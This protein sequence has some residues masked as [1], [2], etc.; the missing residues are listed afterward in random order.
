MS[1]LAMIWMSSE[2]ELGLPRWSMAVCLLP[3]ACLSHMVLKQVRSSMQSTLDEHG[4]AMRT[5]VTST[6]A[7]Q[8]WMATFIQLATLRVTPPSS[9]SQR[10]A[11]SSVELPNIQ[12]ISPIP[13]LPTRDK[14]NRQLAFRSI[15]VGHLLELYAELGIP[16]W[17]DMPY[18][19]P[20]RSTTTD[21]GRQAI[22]PASARTRAAYATVVNKGV[23]SFA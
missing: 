11:S 16:D 8:S 2:L 19:N 13:A 18:F 14:K 23:P 4:E 7:S 1:Y 6:Y 20:A 12:A 5:S 10:S 17:C 22:I 15:N 3:M 21:V 9:A